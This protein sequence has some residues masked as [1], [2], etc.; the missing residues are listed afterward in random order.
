MTVALLSKWG[1]QPPGTLYTTDSATEAAMIT[2]KVATATLTGATAWVKPGNSPGAGAPV[3][4]NIDTVTGGVELVAGG[5]RIPRDAIDQTIDGYPIVFAPNTTSIVGSANG[6]WSNV[7]RDGLSGIGM[8]ANASIA[9]MSID[10]NCDSRTMAS[11]NLG[12]LI[13]LSGMDGEAT[14][15]AKFSLSDGSGYT[16]WF[17]S[18]TITLAQP[19][20][21]WIPIAPAAA[22][23]TWKWSVG[24]GAP[25]FGTTLF[26]RLRVRFDFTASKRPSCEFYSV[27]ENPRS[28]KPQVVFSFDDG[29]DSVYNLAVP[30]L[31]KYRL[32]ATCAIIA[33]LIG[34]AGYM[35]NA[36]LASLV[37][38]AHEMVP[39]G[40]IGG[41]GSL[42]NYVASPTRYAD[43]AADVSLHRN[44]LITNGLAKNGSEN[45]YVFPQGFTAFGGNG[46]GN[47]EILDALKSV[48][49][50]MGRG[51]S[52][53][54][55]DVF[56]SSVGVM[57]NIM[58]LPIAGH[59]WA[60]E[61]AEV[62]NIAAIIQRVRDA[63]MAGHHVVLMFHKC[64]TGTPTQS[65]E[66]KQ[67]NLELIASAVAD[68]I[69]VGRMQ[70]GTMTSLY[71]ALA[72]T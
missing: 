32:K 31:E 49:V 50:V 27:F 34:Q 22:G 65:L 35:T 33:D 51:V 56:P 19:G 58:V 41:A 13:Y 20:Y 37:S 60:S 21:Y 61:G 72:Q 54:T 7:S 46:S 40:P 1:D 69:S 44:F 16:N 26:T 25:V 67:S 63:G 18:S 45:I 10:V 9:N 64:V 53:T 68:E 52:A 15:G 36:N 71:R 24:G 17:T 47:T 2:A 14:I 8:A 66:I 48:G 70:A 39:H 38:R 23:Q 3:T 29:Y 11:G 4:S 6:A 42:N 5:V 30:S 57:K 43:V 28:T 12:F 62:A 59:S 55:S